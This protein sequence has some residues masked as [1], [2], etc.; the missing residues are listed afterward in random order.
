MAVSIEQRVDYL[1]KKLGFTLS[2]TDTNA[3]KSPS[4][5]SIPSPLIIPGGIIWSESDPDKIP[6]T[7]PSV[8]SQYVKVFSPGITSSFQ[9]TMDPTSTSRRAF[10]AKQGSTILGDWIDKQFGSLYE[11]KVF[12][13]N[14]N[15]SGSPTVQ[16]DPNGTSTNGVS[17]DDTWFFDY[18]SG[19]LN[20]NGTTIPSSVLTNNIFIVGWR[21]IGAKGVVSSGGQ[22]Q[23]SLSIANLAVSGITTLGVGNSAV[24]INSGIVTSSTP[25]FSTVTFVGNFVGTASSAGFAQTAFNL[26]S[27]LTTRVGFAT[28]ATDVI[29]G[30]ASVTSLSVSGFSTVGVLTA[31]TIGIGTTNPTAELFVIG[32]SNISGIVTIGV[33][34]SVVVIS[35]GIITSSGVGTVTYFGNLTGTASTASFATTAFNL[36]GFTPSTGSVGFATTAT[37]VIGGIGSLSQLSVSGLTT[38]GVLTATRIGIGTTNPTAELFVVGNTNISGVSTFG[39]TSIGVRIIGTSGIITSSSS[40]IG[41]VTY[42]G[43]GS[44][45]TGIKGVSVEFQSQTAQTLFPTLAA[46]SGVSSIGIATTGSTAFCYIPSSGNLGIGTTNPTSKLFVN[47]NVFV[48]GIATIG[49]G[50]SAIS[51]NGTAGIITASGVGTVTYF[52]D[53]SKLTGIKGVTVEFQ[54]QTAET[55]FPTLAANSGVSSI[56][57]AT[58]GSTAFCYIPSSGNIGI[59]TTTPTA[60]LT[61]NGNASISGITTVGVGT[62][63]VVINGTTGIITSINPLTTVTFVGNLTGTASTTSFATTSFTLNGRTESQF[64]VAFAQTAG[65]STNVIGGI[66]SITQLSVSG[67]TTSSEFVGGGSDLRSLQG[68]NLV[69]Y[70]S[71]SES[72]NSSSSISGISTYIEIAALSGTFVGFEDE[73]GW[74]VATSADG[75][76]IVVGARKDEL[77]EFSAS[78]GIV[79]VFDRNGNSFNQVGILTGTFTGTSDFFG[80]SVATSADGKTIIVGSTSDGLP[81]ADGTGLVYVFDRTGNSF[82]QVGILTGSNAIDA[83]DDFGICVATSADGKTIIVGASADETTISGSGLVYVFDRNGNEFNQVGILSSGIFANTNDEFGFSVATSADGKTIVV[84]APADQTAGSNTGLVYIFERNGNSFNQVGILTGTNSVQSEDLFGYSVAISADGKTIAVGAKD[85]EI[86]ANPATGIVY[87]YDRVVNSFNQ[88][89]ILTGTFSTQ[90][91]DRFGNSVAISADGKRIVVGAMEDEISPPNNTGVV[92]VFNRVGNTFNRVASIRGSLAIES[93]DKFG[94]CVAVS[95]DGKSI[96]A[97]AFEDSLVFGGDIAGLAYVFDEVKETYLHSN[98]QGNI[99]IGTSNPTSK[100][101]V[102]GGDIRVGIN[103]SQGMILTSPD[104]TKYRLI[105]ANGGTLSTVVVP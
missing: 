48:S 84:G 40:G 28:T 45:L 42:F 60:K 95:A 29:G 12:A 4:N 22:Q 65:I 8:D 79:Y 35:A 32:N 64:N 88:V 49:T 41:T 6:P 16:L 9:M 19:V 27:P 68:T 57:I 46:N 25:G 58:T 37:N 36:Q 10:I 11:I 33:G 7:P 59:G 26:N 81:G 75:K 72:S 97:G 5:E 87:V 30:I 2:K 3:N 74:S 54:A 38:V 43:D 1:F 93:G 21:Y 39:N 53:G 92:Y 98:T 31:T 69:S 18:S 47:G 34:N 103:T 70:S 50:I 96:I 82:N 13:N 23:T 89:G 78:S 52:G 17:N 55:L 94:K 83:G 76:T 71:Y 51:L 44:N 56:G 62:I 90:S 66:G 105:V 91:G 67:V 102:L 14:P 63:G 100:L 61:V 73:F 20:F 15:G 24:A 80:S 85:D 77:D 99:G 86:G 104:G 101:Q